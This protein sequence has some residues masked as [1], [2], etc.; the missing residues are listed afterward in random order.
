[1]LYSAKE[2]KEKSKSADNKPKDEN[3]QVKSKKTEDKPKDK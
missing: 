3:P 2:Y 1:M